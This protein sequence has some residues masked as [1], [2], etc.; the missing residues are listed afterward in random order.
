MGSARILLAALHLPNGM[1]FYA[2]QTGSSMRSLNCSGRHCP[3]L[4]RVIPSDPYSR[5]PRGKWLALWSRR[6]VRKD[7]H[8]RG[9]GLP[10]SSIRPFAASVNS[11]AA[12]SHSSY[13]TLDI[14]GLKCGGCVS[15]SE[16]ALARISGVDQAS[17]NLVTGTAKVKLLGK[18]S[19]GIR[20]WSVQSLGYFDHRR[21]EVNA[22]WFGMCNP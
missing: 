12:A 18:Q 5:I 22:D 4:P 19:S 2:C 16:K 17:V 21:L 11:T 3:Q 15:K 8:L 6:G 10:F 20:M 13:V 9:G 7:L 14:Q 1:R